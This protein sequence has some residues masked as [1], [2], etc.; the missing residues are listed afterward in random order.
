MEEE[1]KLTRCT[2]NNCLLR[3][4]C[5]RFTKRDFKED[6]MYFVEVPYE[7]NKKD[8]SYLWNDNAEW[9][10]QELERLTEPTN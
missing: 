8:C 6:E 7:A 10:Y 4:H 1:E 9:L 5:H 2:G 3:F